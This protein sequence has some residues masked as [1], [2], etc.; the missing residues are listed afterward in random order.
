MWTTHPGSVEGLDKM[1]DFSIIGVKLKIR[2]KRR[3]EMKRLL[4]IFVAVCLVLSVAIP[5]TAGRYHRH[6]HHH[7]RHYYDDGRHE[8]KA[9][10]V[11]MGGLVTLFTLNRVL[12]PRPVVVVQQAPAY[13]SGYGG[14][15]EPDCS[16]YADPEVRNACEQG[17]A[18]TRRRIKEKEKR[19][20]YEHGRNSG[21]R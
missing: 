18:E 9:P 13:G 4:I 10:A 8:W 21:W 2:K 11:I 14:Y 12:K 5:A 16:C 7:Y 19:L 17:K 1:L 15:T 3:F 20:A 6:R